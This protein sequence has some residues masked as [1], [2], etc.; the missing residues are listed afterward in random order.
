MGDAETLQAENARLRRELADALWRRDMLAEQRDNILARLTSTQEEMV[1]L[2]QVYSEII[3]YHRTA[4]NTAEYL[5]S[6][7]KSILRV[8][9]ALRSAAADL[10]GKGR[11]QSPRT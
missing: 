7:A 3:S 6:W 4:E 10:P 8:A 11:L 5:E 1:R 2:Q 9:E